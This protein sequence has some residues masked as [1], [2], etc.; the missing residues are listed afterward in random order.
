MT[1]ERNRNIDALRVV[2]AVGV[3]WSHSL[4]AFYSS[5]EWPRLLAG[6]I[7]VGRA[8]VPFFFFA[9]GWAYS[10]S[11]ERHGNRALRRRV[12]QLAG[13]FAAAWLFSMAAGQPWSWW[14]TAGVRDILAA[15]FY[16]MPAGPLWFFPALIGATLVGHAIAGRGMTGAAAVLAWV[17]FLAG[18]IITALLPGIMGDKAAL[19]NP[20]TPGIVLYRT[21]V[22]WCGAYLTGMALAE[23]GFAPDGRQTLALVLA[24]VT[25][26]AIT[27]AMYLVPVA[28]LPRWLAGSLTSIAVCVYS[29]GATSLGAAALTPRSGRLVEL[30]A[31][32]GPLALWVYVV[33]PVVMTW[34]TRLFPTA[35]WGP[36][37]YTLAVAAVSFA[38]ATVGLSAWRLLYS[39]AVHPT[40]PRTAP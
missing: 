32:A 21:A 2:A 38:A 17:A 13:I 10:G 20:L 16:G 31:K 6:L 24:G 37:L 8:G 15:V 28:L 34:L 1:A 19:L 18:V 29:A 25:G 23:R 27:L 36:W 40:R 26:L 14:S 11:L 30:V 3:L 33:H 5:Y 12:L 7:L 22:Y 35:S 4:N 39:V 9:A